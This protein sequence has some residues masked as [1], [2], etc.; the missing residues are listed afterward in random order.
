MGFIQFFSSSLFLTAIFIP[1]IY[2]MFNL[3]YSIFLNGFSNKFIKNEKLSFVCD[4][5][6]VYLLTHIIVFMAFTISQNIC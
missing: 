6:A 3:I 1:I 5:A 2:T 4:M